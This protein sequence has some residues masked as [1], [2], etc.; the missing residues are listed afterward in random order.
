M[1]RGEQ[2]QKNVSGPSNPPDELA[3]NVSKKNPRRTNYSSIFSAKVQNLTVFQLH[4]SNSIFCTQG[5]KSEGVSGRHSIPAAGAPSK[6]RPPATARREGAADHTPLS[7]PR[8]RRPRGH[9]IF[10]H[11]QKKTT[12]PVHNAWS[13]H[14]MSCGVPNGRCY[15]L[16]FSSCGIEV[17]NE[18]LHTQVDKNTTATSG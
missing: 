3:Q 12:L 4:D 11:T 17:R 8:L 15:M 14:S 7:S 10:H 16:L 18:F 2:I 6:T 9:H 13:Q 5:I 1:K